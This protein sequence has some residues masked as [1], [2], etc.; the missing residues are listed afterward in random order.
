MDRSI[1]PKNSG[2][3]LRVLGLPFGLAAIV[4]GMVGAGILRTPGLVAGQVF[5]PGWIIALWIA[6]AVLVAITALAY[7][8][9]G[10]AMPSA[11]GPYDFIRRAFGPFPGMAGVPGS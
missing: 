4:G 8:E 7:V 2:I 11:G 3:L 10:S 5:A 9:L 1:S 6:G